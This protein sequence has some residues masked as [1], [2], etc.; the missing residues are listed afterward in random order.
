MDHATTTSKLVEAPRWWRLAAVRAAAA[1]TGT[2]R[3]QILLAFLVMSAITGALG[4]YAALEIR[5]AGVLVAETFDKSLMAINYAR[6]ASADFTAMQAALAR[7][8][9]A[10]DPGTQANLDQRIEALA[11]SLDEDLTIA[12][13]R[14]QSPRAARAAANARQAVNTWESERRRLSVHAAPEDA[15]R[16][17]DRF[18]ATVD[19]Q[20]NLLVNYTAGD[21]FTYRQRAR[22]AVAADTQ[23]NLA[24]TAAALLLS[25]L[26]A[27]LLAR[28]ITRPV[29]AASAV[30]ARIARGE[31]DG[32]IP[33]GSADELGALL[34]AMK[35]MRD[36]IRAMMERE[37]AQRRSAQARLADALEGS[38]EGVVVVDAEGCVA[39]ANPRAADL[40]GISADLL[41]PGAPFARLATAMADPYEGAALL[42][43]LAGDLPATAEA[44]LMDGRWLRISQNATQEGGFIAVCSDVTALKDQTARLEAA[45]LWL[46]AAL[47]N[48]AQ[49]LCLYDAENRLKVVNRRFCEIFR[50]A[51]DRVV[52]GISF[53]E[54]LEMSVAAGNHIGR[55]AGGLLAEE[56]GIA[57]LRAS[58]DTRFQELSHG[59]VIAISRQAMADGGWVATYEDVTE[60]QRAEAQIV[61]MARH[62][63]LTGLPNRVLF[64]ERVE[65]ALAQAGRDEDFAV[66][67]LD[68]DRFKAVNDTLGHPVGDELL[69]AVAER[70]QAC[71][72]EVDTVARLGGDEFAIVQSGVAKAEDA[73]VLARRIV[74]VVSQPYELDGHRIMI[75]TSV[76]ISIAPGDGAS[77]GKLLKNADVA[78]YKTKAEG[79]GTWRFFEPDMDARLQARRALE[80]DL[81]AAL[82]ND[83]FEL[84]Y[85]PLFDL[86]AN[87]IG[88]FE[89]LLRWRHPKHGM[90]S[91]ADFIPISEEIGLIVPLGDW[92]LQR[93]CA[94]ASVWP[95]HVK[96]AVN[97]SPAQFRTGHLVDSV[98]KALAASGLPAARLELEITE[99]VLL[100]N[101]AATLA[102]LHALRA[103]GVRISMDDFGTGYSSL[104]YLR[105]FPFDKIKIDQ[106]FIRDLATTDDAEA[107]VRAIIGLGAS[108]GMRTTA[109]GVETDEQLAWLRGE[110]CT[111][112][113][114]YLFSP[115]VPAAELPALIERW[116]GS[117]G[118]AA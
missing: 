37:V 86:R 81:W 72:R 71:V 109:E 89:A 104:S 59:R 28:R 79:R 112:V 93:A 41:R 8:W 58:G 67:L 15:W 1:R 106:S 92:V 46:D 38:H 111:E 60:R 53:R 11:H 50:L 69:R 26:V 44:R 3:G 113:Q 76:G 33:H 87:R 103:L 61:F 97:V 63:A 66:L 40:L 5:H 115:S 16:A 12:A 52:P 45:N 84:H 118:A 62:D 7:R 77:C 107:I 13:E 2:I 20:I 82:A 19:Q 78:L 51:P 57:D 49:G 70:L 32:D 68:L 65:Q 34:A 73:A 117:V 22:A 48:I 25:A 90:V 43:R 4:G 98:T 36:N 18:A 110:D 17:L 96:V 88:G 27:W 114:G 91:P 14:S 9:S 23:L 83:Q 95:G 116:R 47:G 94:E 21:G 74:E 10:A 55:S 24:G 100:A 99:S 101:S 102:T 42:R 75:G 54:V 29:A 108:L 39:L 35:V 6:A 80:L 105:S 31:L 56:A 64:H 85:Q 30:A